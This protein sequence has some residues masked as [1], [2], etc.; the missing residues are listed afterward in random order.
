ML[1]CVVGML[2]AVHLQALT[3]LNASA[4]MQESVK[5]AAD[6]RAVRTFTGK[7][8]RTSQHFECAVGDE[9]FMGPELLF[10]PQAFTSEWSASLP[11]VVDDVIQSC[12][13]DARRP[14][15]GNIALS[16][17]ITGQSCC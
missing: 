9:A 2:S 10:S 16:V 17:S 5:R 11:Q 15:Y 1:I 14:L 3:I 8:D 13:I 6:P 7:D 12:P 4:D